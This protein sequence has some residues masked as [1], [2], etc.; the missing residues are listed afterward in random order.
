MN[1]MPKIAVI[2]SRNEYVRNYLDSGAFQEILAKHE[3]TLFL[4]PNLKINSIQKNGFCGVEFLPNLTNDVIGQFVFDLYMIRY[5]NRS[6]SFRYRI[7]RRFPSIFW[8]LNYLLA[9]RN[10]T[11]A[12]TGIS[13]GAEK[14]QTKFSS[15][16]K[17]NSAKAKIRHLK[18]SLKLLNS[19]LKGK[20]KKFLYFTLASKLFFPLTIRVLRRLT[21]NDLKSLDIFHDFSAVIIPSSAYEYHSS[22]VIRNAKNSKTKSILLIDNWDNLSSKSVLWEKPDVL[23]CWGEQSKEHAVQ[24]QK[25]PEQS[26]IPI[27]TPRI[28]PYFNLRSNYLPSSFSFRY[29]LFLGSSVPYDEAGFLK[30]LDFEIS[31]NPEIYQ[32]TR[33]IYRPH[34]L[35]GGWETADMS[36]LTATLLDPDL[37]EAYLSGAIRWSSN[38]KLP[39]LDNY[40]PLLANSEMVVT[41]M[42]SMIFEA[43]IFGKYCVGLAFDEKWNL[44]NPKKLLSEYLHFHGIEELP[45]LDLFSYQLEAIENIR[46]F[47]LSGKPL[48]QSEV[49]NKLRYFL[50]HD[51]KTYTMRLSD[52]VQS[53]LR[54]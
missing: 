50:H 30:R 3:V 39:P 33:I 31:N 36:Q 49:D 9:H 26:V 54:D 27:G 25:M 41:G 21:L 4:S 1:P 34:P 37:E 40:A 28:D 6:S 11:F 24:I 13:T 12:L 5:R 22:L 48:D 38:T 19:L 23:G 42:T 10:S 2:I 15:I 51:Q 44:T 47:F 53:A 16:V 52:L 14:K 35:R 17:S 46:N 7:K 45:N 18:V 20:G 29:I 43:S 32:T 8:Q